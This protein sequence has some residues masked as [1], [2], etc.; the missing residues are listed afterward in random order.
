VFLVSRMHEAHRH[1]MA[2]AEAV[3]DGFRKSGPVVLAA[4]A[5]MTAVF[6]GFALSPSSLVGSI[7][8][9]LTVGVLADALLVRMILM[10][11]V[12][13]IMGRA[14]WW[15]P[16]WLDRALPSIDVE[17]EALTSRGNTA[18]SVR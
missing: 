10:P 9:A 1:G 2:P 18:V 8:M 7:A 16:R 11:A 4:A 15:M 5:I 12:L 14:A 17:G 13:T 6:A 3:R